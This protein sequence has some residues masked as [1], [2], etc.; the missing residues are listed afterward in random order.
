MFSYFIITKE[1]MQ[2]FQMQYSDNYHIE[3]LY[4]SAV[5]LWKIIVFFF[6]ISFAVFLNVFSQYMMLLLFFTLHGHFDE[7]HNKYQWEDI[8]TFRN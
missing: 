7:F 4:M 3:Q 2:W 1:M 5:I 6:L 8:I